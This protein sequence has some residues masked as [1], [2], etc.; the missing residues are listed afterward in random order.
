[1]PLLIAEVARQSKS[2]PASKLAQ[3][4]HILKKAGV[5]AI[6]VRTD[7]DDT[8]TGLADLFA[9]VRAVP[10]VPVLRRDW[11]IHPL[12]V[13]LSLHAR[14]CALQH[15]QAPVCYA[16]KLY[17]LHCSLSGADCCLGSKLHVHN[18]RAGD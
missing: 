8:D 13:C 11:F 14:H 16:M 9:V 4:A 5:H 12:Q 15:A 6:C 1:M 7:A 17:R 3:R 10:D 18:P 2:E